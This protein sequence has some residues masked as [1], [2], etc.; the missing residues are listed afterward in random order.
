MT[1]YWIYNLPNWF[2]GILCIATFVAYG[3]LG[4]LLTRKWVRRLH[5]TDHSHNDIVGYYLG[6]V[7]VFYGITLGL[8][9]VGTW[10]TY[11]D[12]QAKVDREAQTMASL[13]R[14]VN[15]YPEP[16]RGALT[17]DLKQYTREVVDHSWPQ[18]R[19]G[20][21]PIGSAVYLDQFQTDLLSFEPATPGQQILHAEAYK[22]FNNLVEA[23]RSRLDAVTASLPASLWSMVLLGAIICIAVTFFF[24]T[25]S[26]PM[27][28]WMTGLT[29]GLLGLLIFLV[30]T[31]DNPFRGKVSVGPQALERVYQQVMK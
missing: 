28:V 12:V 24:D 7:T 17:D 3:L 29:A 22:Q 5:R 6:A 8:V 31:L 18:Q 20:I 2:F 15:H 1:L 23:R 4:L 27:H 10:N 26:F 21:V 11:S 16:I 25:A 9:A 14:D 13:Y 30:A 19:R